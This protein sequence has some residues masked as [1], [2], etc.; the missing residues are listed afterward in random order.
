MMIRNIPACLALANAVAVTARGT[1]EFSLSKRDASGKQSD[2]ARGV[3]WKRQDTAGTV[4]ESVYDVLPWSEGGAYY[5]NISVGTPPQVQTVILDTGSSDTYLDARD[6]SACE[7]TGVYSCRGGTFDSGSS[8]TYKVTIQDGFETA[9]GDGSSASGNFGTDVV[10]IGDVAISNV[11][12]GLASDVNSTTGF[13]VGLMGIGYSLN[14]ASE[15]QYAN[16][17]EVLVDAG[18]INSRLY[19][20]FLN[21]I[22]DASGTILFGGI[23]TSKYTGQLN[24]LNLLP[25]PLPVEGGGTEDYVYEFVV[26]VTAVSADNAGKSQSYLSGGSPSGGNGALMVLLDTGSAAWTVPN[27]LYDD[28]VKLLPD[29]DEYGNLPC[30]TQ[31]D[32]ISLNLTFGA[33]VDITVPISELIVPIFDPLTNAQNTT[34]DGQPLCTFMMSPGQTSTDQPFLT[35]G[36]AILRSMYVVFDLDNGQVSIAQART[37]T[38]TDSSSSASGDNIK[39]VKAGADGVAS[40]VGSSAVSTVASNTYTIA[41]PASATAT[42]KFSVVTESSAVGTATGTNAIPEAGR[43][44]ES[45][46]ASAASATSGSGTSGSS[47]SAKASSSKGV[48]AGLVVPPAKWSVF[49]SASMVMLGMGAGAALML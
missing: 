28:I 38:S 25:V 19:S 29:I 42:A 1:L 34:T 35:L 26:A 13:A 14:E 21:D 18:V 8:S 4:E 6:A 10:Q 41:P 39:V 11:Q 49:F 22:G 47:T 7:S 16:M 23:D 9:F 36:D 30:S 45:S 17:P 37:N 32:N 31:S 5:T 3:L 43:V 24:T 44:T 27:K 46:D 33:A 40:A 12:F 20:V 48:A 2:I 15:T